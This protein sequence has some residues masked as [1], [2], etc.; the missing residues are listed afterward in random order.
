MKRLFNRRS[1][2]RSGNTSKNEDINPWLDDDFDPTKKE[3]MKRLAK[4][5]EKQIKLDNALRLTESAQMEK[6]EYSKF[7]LPL[8]MRELYQDLR[9]R[10]GVMVI[11]G[12]YLVDK[13]PLSKLVAIF[14]VTGVVNASYTGTDYF[15]KVVVNGI[16]NETFKNKMRIVDPAWYLFPEELRAIVEIDRKLNDVT[17]TIPSIGAMTN[18]TMYNDHMIETRSLLLQATS[19]WKDIVNQIGYNTLGSEYA[20][21]LDNLQDKVDRLILTGDASAFMRYCAMYHDKKAIKLSGP[22]NAYNLFFLD[23]Q[24]LICI[25]ILSLHPQQFSFKSMRGK[26]V[27]QR[28]SGEPNIVREQV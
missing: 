5:N 19:R 23:G 28:P 7:L 12:N 20:K 9:A 11:N 1:D 2:A 24:L 6:F 17:V 8:R 3:D 16:S 14:G 13:V 4:W 22:N 25:P 18:V 15:G 27:Q 21:S 10:S 26:G